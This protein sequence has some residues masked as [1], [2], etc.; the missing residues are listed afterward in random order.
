MTAPVRHAKLEGKP[1]EEVGATEWQLAIECASKTCKVGRQ[2][3]TG[4]WGNKVA[5]SQ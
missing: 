5:L 2:I 4:R 3:V 1:S